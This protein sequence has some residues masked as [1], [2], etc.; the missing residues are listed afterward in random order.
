MTPF[1]LRKNL[2]ARLVLSRIDYGITVS[3]DSNL[4]Q[5]MKRRVQKLIKLL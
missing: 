3:Y 1:N 5:Y 4:Q 2:A